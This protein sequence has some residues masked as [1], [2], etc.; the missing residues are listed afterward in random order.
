VADTTT[1]RL[2][3]LIRQL[4]GA[5][6][7]AP[8]AVPTLLNSWAN[9]DADR[10]ARYW[11]VGTTVCLSGIV[12][13]GVIGSPIFTLPADYCPVSVNGLIFPVVSND[14]FGIAIVTAAGA[15]YASA[16][17]NVYFSLDGICFSTR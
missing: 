10:P 5:L 7:V 11:K 8:V 4:Q 14:A 15:V 17:S 2:W 6:M 16:G 1:D 12:K 9:F 3:A 13:S